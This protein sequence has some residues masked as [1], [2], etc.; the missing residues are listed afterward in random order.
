MRSSAARTRL[1]AVAA[2]GLLL[3]GAAPAFAGD[4]VGGGGVAKPPVTT[5]STPA[6]KPKPV[7]LTV[8]T[9]N[10]YLGSSL[11]PALAAKSGAEFLAAVSQIYATVQ[12]T[13]FPARAK[14][15][16]ASIK[17]LQP[18]F[19]SLQEVSKWTF[20]R[21]N[22]GPAVPSYDFWGIL[23]KELKALGMRYKVVAV[24][25][26]ASILSPYVSPADNCVTVSSA[27]AADCFLQFNDR[28]VI[29]VNE[30]KGIGI[31]KSRRGTYDAQEV[32]ASPA[33][34]L[35]FARG[36]AY[37]DAV[38]K[39]VKFRFVNSHL[40]TEDFPKVQVAQG[41]EL[42]AGPSRYNGP[43]IATG[44]Y[45]SAT[46]GSTTPTYKNLTK[47]YFKD[48]WSVS[49]DGA[50]LSC[51]QNETLSNTTSELKTRIDLVLMHGAVKAG[52]AQLVGATPFTS[53]PAP[54]WASDHAGVFARL[55]VG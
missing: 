37:V 47:S 26:N 21:T 40:E 27:F 13:D 8:M 12:K 52:K 10:L 24:A 55:T 32:I 35:S 14:A 49:R 15:V 1:V 9:Q 30:A 34:D 17:K 22:D 6:P 7:A 29:A 39:G 46:D 23:N 18:D 25:N 50:G 42:L 2:A 36:W 48:A 11:N 19:L 43:V 33:G 38:Y 51:C 16:A 54:L 31:T 3:A 45:N 28:D 20:K 44:D 4:V 41:A 5:P 53:G